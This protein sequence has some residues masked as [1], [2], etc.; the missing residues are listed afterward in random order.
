MLVFAL[1]PAIALADTTYADSVESY[2]P[3]TQ[4]NGDPIVAGRDDPSAAL[5]APDGNFVSLG[6]GGELVL[7]FDTPV[8]GT[9]EVTVYEITT[10]D[11]PLEEADVYVST[12]GNSWDF[13]GTADNLDEGDTSST[14]L[15]ELLD[16]C[17]KYVKLVD[18]TDSELHN[19][20]SDGFDVEAVRAEYSETCEE[21]KCDECGP[22]WA[23]VFIKNMNSSY[24]SNSA[25]TYA[26][27]GNNSADGGN[28]GQAGAGGNVE[29][30]QDDNTGGNGGN[31][32]A[33]GNGGGIMT[34][35]ATA[36]ALIANDVNNVINRVDRACGCEEECPCAPANR[37]I[38][39]KNY[40]SAMTMNGGGLIAAR[41][42]VEAG[43]DNGF[44]QLPPIQLGGIFTEA[45]TGGNEVDGGGKYEH[46][47]IVLKT[48]PQ[49]PPERGNDGGNVENSEDDNTG[50]NGGRSGKGGNGGVIETGAANA[51]TDIMNRINTVI[52]NI[53]R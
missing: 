25:M 46:N 20:T 19:A 45:N 35:A 44:D 33:G 1:T 7:E 37:M 18:V 47:H 29:N 2:T 31:G 21:E 26:N 12:D 36:M 22:T 28:G 32:G 23:P 3:G 9:L 38:K 39:I 6:Y 17:V 14:T 4:K 11:Y 53:R 50:G 41:N 8:G 42:L 5:G 49:G 52:N 27:S 30:S 13:L 34:G 51:M 10:G 16:T 40:N 43:D 48:R 24:L 15:F